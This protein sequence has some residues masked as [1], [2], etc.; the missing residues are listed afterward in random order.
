MKKLSLALALALMLSLAACGSTPP[1]ENLLS[2]RRPSG[3]ELSGEAADAV[4]EFSLSASPGSRAPA[5]C[6]PRSPRSSP[7]A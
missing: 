7:W 4:V 6:C 2:G 1:A 5:P 3:G